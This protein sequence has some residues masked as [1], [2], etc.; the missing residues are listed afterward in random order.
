MINL[1]VNLSDVDAENICGFLR[2]YTNRLRM[3]ILEAHCSNNTEQ[4]LWLE[5]HLDY[6]NDLI[7]KVTL[8]MVRVP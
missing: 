7:D 3:D 2:S 8:K 4:K 1:N 6:A 5:R